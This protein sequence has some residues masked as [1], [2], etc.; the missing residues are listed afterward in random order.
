MHIHKRSHS[1]VVEERDEPTTVDTAAV[2]TD[3]TAVNQT[4]DESKPTGSVTA[5]VQNKRVKTMY[6]YLEGRPIADEPVLEYVKWCVHG[7]DV[8]KELL[9]FRKICKEEGAK[10]KKLQSC[11]EELEIVI[12]PTLLV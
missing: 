4:A 10:G 8:S 6:H 11:I 2:T 12:A 3:K 5:Q 7:N 9:Q 1:S